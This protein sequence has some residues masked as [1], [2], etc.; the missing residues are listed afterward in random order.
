MKKII[1]LTENK[2]LGI[3]PDPFIFD[4]GE[5]VKNTEDWGERRKEIYKTAVELQ[6]GTI[7]PEPEF[8]EGEKSYDFSNQRTFRITTGTKNV[9]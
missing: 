1:K 6:Y 5:R 9:P 3:L 8:L 2:V 4:N 7:P